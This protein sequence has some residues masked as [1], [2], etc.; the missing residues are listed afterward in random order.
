MKALLIQG[1]RWYNRRFGNTY[2]TATVYIDGVLAF[3]T[4]P[5]YGYGDHFRTV[6][7]EQ[8][9]KRGLLPAPRLKYQT[10]SSE[11]DWIYCQ[12]LGI[13]F[14]YDVADVKREKDL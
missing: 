3:K 9:E 13:T 8:L 12:R 4:E 14:A 2:C 5:T 1:R 10:G 11:A 7:M 6:A